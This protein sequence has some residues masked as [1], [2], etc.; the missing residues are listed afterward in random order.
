M[1]NVVD[2]MKRLFFGEEYEDED[3]YEEMDEYQVEKE[4]D[5][6]ASNNVAPFNKYST[7]RASNSNIVNINTNVQI[8]VCMFNPSNLEDAGD[9]VL[10]IK[11]RNIVVVNLELVEYEM[12]QRISDFLCGA[13][14]GLDGNIQ[15]ISDK[16]IIVAPGNVEMSGELKDKLQASGIKI[17]NSIWN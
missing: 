5:S 2:K 10:Q 8:G 15:P 16:I 1:G 14:Y 6:R 7:R 4:K 12:A 3:D 9:I 17:P 11:D 13:S